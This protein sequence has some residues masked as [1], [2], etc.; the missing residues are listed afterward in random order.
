MP[1]YVCVFAGSTIHFVGFLVLR[2]TFW[3]Q[4]G[5]KAAELSLFDKCGRTNHGQQKQKDL[6]IF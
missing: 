2:F 3:L 5:T 4:N 1:G 6:M